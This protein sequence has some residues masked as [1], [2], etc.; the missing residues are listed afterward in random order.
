M[1]QVIVFKAWE[2]FGD[3]LTVL[4]HLLAYCQKHD[5]AIC[6][7]WRDENWGHGKFDFWDFFDLEGV[8]VLTLEEVGKL[9]GAKIMPETWDMASIMRPITQ[10][11]QRDPFVAEIMR[12]SYE[13][14]TGDIIV[15]NGAG[16][17][18]YDG[19]HVAKHLRFKPKV[20]LEIERRLAGMQLPATV[21]HLRGTDRSDGDAMKGW[22]EKYEALMPHQKERIYH[23]TDDRKVADEWVK[24][25]PQSKLLN[26]LSAVLKLPSSSKQGTHQLCAEA[27]EYYRISK[28]DLTLDALTEFT[29][30]AFATDAIG[31]EKST[32]YQMAR[33]VAPFKAEAVSLLLGGW[34]PKRASLVADRS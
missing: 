26:P 3:R 8:K 4:T 27:L 24:N 23:I 28:W 20:A 21:V 5:A 6:V 1:Q 17:R 25:V 14:G 33:A 29:G 2:G 12:E 31:L 18:R 11:Q 34:M 10:W 13:K 22:L 15:T 32:F 7:D 30:L 16:W 9:Q 19:Y